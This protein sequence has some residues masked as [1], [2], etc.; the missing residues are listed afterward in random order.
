MMNPEK[1][2]ELLPL[3]EKIQKR[4]GCLPEKELKKLSIKLGM[5]LS[6]IF[7]VASFY[8]HL[9]LKARGKNI[10]RVCNNPSCYV[11]GSMNII[12]LIEKELK[13]KSGQTTKDKKFYLEIGSCIGCC[14]KPP[15]MMINDKVFDSLTKDKVKKILKKYKK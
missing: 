9:E 2:A 10:I 6:E 12:H 1:R 13:I 7:G 14:D 5:P 8:A 15:A 3:L 11:N 4:Y